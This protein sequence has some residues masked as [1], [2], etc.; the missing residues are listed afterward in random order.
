MALAS[1]PRSASRRRTRNLSPAR[2]RRPVVIPKSQRD[3]WTARR[4]ARAGGEAADQIDWT[5]ISP[6]GVALGTRL[7]DA[8]V[9]IVI[10]RDYG[11]MPEIWPLLHCL[12]RRKKVTPEEGVGRISNGR[13]ISIVVWMPPAR[14]LA[15]GSLD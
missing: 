8:T 1:A 2:W 5:S 7:G 3:A 6:N 10:T 4:L 9:I 15:N 14:P 11:E 12:E 13:S